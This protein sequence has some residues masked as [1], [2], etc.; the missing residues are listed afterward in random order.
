MSY[1]ANRRLRSKL[2]IALVPLA[3]MVVVAAL[4]SSIESKTINAWYIQLIDKDLSV[5]Q[6]LTD[7]R[8]L[9]ALY[10]QLLYKDIAELDPDRMQ[11]IEGDLDK[12]YTD[13]RTIIT[14][15]VRNSPNHAKEI[16]AADALFDRAV[17]DAR[18]VRAAAL[19]YDNKKAMNLM[20]GSVDAELREAR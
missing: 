17:S 1:L 18:P 2:L 5:L 4:Y 7:A 6:E 9:Q 16:N 14:E 10:G 3:A 15:A 11:I 12:T 13:Y 20:R 19:I 8:G